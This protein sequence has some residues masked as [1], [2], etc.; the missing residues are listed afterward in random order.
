MKQIIII[1][2]FSLFQL[3]LFSQ[4]KLEWTEGYVLKVENFKANAPNT[5]TIQTV[6]GHTT[7]EYQIM[8]YDMMFSNNFNKNVTCYFYPN[9]SWIDSGESTDQ[10]LKYAQNVFDIY[11]WMARELRKRFRENKS[12]LIAGKHNEIY[13]Q[14]TK[15]FAEIQSQFEKETNHGTNEDKQNEWITKINA[16]I[17]SLSD[18][19]KTCKPKKSK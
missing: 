12:Q 16:K 1:W 4:D 15:E 11:E 10:L 17:D 13:N 7:I 2:I 14:V 6:Q 3:N 5:G 8:N 9:A 19:C 18:Y